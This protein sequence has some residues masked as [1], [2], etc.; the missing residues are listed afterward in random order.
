VLL[1]YWVGQNPKGRHMW[2]GLFTS[3]IG[4]PTKDY[5]PQEVI[6]QIGV[7]RARP[8][9]S[10]HVHFSMAA[11]MENRK[12]ISDQLKA[13]QYATPALV[14]ASPWLGS[15]KPG[16]PGVSARNGAA[17]V[18]LRLA[19]GHRTAHY[20]IWSRHGD[21][22][23]FAVAPGS[24]SDWS[25]PHD[26]ALGAANAVFVNAVDRIGSESAPVRVLVK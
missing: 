17:A 4:A 26:P 21:Q 20:A 23:R 6:A 18:T 9:A 14:P 1:D 11:L 3:R 8:A 19:P 13:G 5:P 7:T 10:G 24:R 16:V 25:I 15:G 22:W 2:P 12:G